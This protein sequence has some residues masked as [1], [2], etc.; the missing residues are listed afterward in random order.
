MARSCLPIP[1]GSSCS[2]ISASAVSGQSRERKGRLTGARWW[3]SRS[4][5]FQ[6]PQSRSCWSGP[7]ALHCIQHT[8]HLG[9]P[10]L[11]VLIRRHGRERGQQEKKPFPVL[12][13]NSKVTGS[14]FQLC[15]WRSGCLLA[16][17]L[18]C[19]AFSLWSK[20]YAVLHHMAAPFFSETDLTMP[21]RHDGWSNHLPVVVDLKYPPRDYY[22]V[23]RY[24]TIFPCISSVDLGSKRGTKTPTLHS[25]VV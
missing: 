22:R 25:T 13:V 5:L 11:R 24:S 20:C 10:I 14:C 4:S 6:E 12:P 2:C 19:P 16:C 18:P 9:E 7:Q 21:V 1:T 15:S 3:L 17:A 23:G 8:V